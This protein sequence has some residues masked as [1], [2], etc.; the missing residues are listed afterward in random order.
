[1]ASNDSR[2]I[3]FRVSE[4]EKH[5]FESAARRM[6]ESLAGLFRYEMKDHFIA[7]ER[8]QLL[9]ELKENSVAEDSSA[10]DERR[11]ELLRRMLLINGEALRWYKNKIKAYQRQIDRLEKTQRGYEQFEQKMQELLS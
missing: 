2:S 9:Q 8:E 6:E 5:W 11:A 1:M 3:N 7:I 10:K 4:A